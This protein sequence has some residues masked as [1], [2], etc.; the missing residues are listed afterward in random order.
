MIKKPGMNEEML[1]DREKILTDTVELMALNERYGLGLS[2]SEYV[3][4]QYG[5][6]TGL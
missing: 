5:E 4:R 6:N 3:Y 2:V 1:R